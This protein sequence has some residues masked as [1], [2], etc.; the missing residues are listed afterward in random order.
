MFFLLPKGF[1]KLSEIT[2]KLLAGRLVI[3]VTELP[4]FALT[5]LPVFYC[6]ESNSENVTF[7]LYE[8]QTTLPDRETEEDRVRGVGTESCYWMFCGNCRWKIWGGIW[9]ACY[10]F[11]NTSRQRN[12]WFRKFKFK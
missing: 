4:M 2:G 8:L 7:G 5:L 6:D 11:V 12:N 3:K 1:F 9:K 10:F